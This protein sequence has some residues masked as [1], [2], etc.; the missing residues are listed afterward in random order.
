MSTPEIAE[1]LGAPSNRLFVIMDA[2]SA[3]DDTV[4]LVTTVSNGGTSQ[5]KGAAGLQ[6]VRATFDWTQSVLVGLDIG[7][8]GFEEACSIAAGNP[9]GVYGAKR[10]DYVAPRKGGSTPRKV[11]GGH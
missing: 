5:D 1:Q 8:Q 4:L 6:T 2:R 3:E 9:G 7:T 10:G 11:L